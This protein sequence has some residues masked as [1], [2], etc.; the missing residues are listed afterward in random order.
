MK[1]REN[2]GVL[3]HDVAARDRQ[4]TEETGRTLNGSIKKKDLTQKELENLAK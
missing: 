4:E 2:L 3:A 1:Q